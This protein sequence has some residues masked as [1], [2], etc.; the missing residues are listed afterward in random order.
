MPNAD[1]PGNLSR[2]T[3]AK[4]NKPKPRSSGSDALNNQLQA[5]LGGSSAL[6]PPTVISPGAGYQVPFLTAPTIGAVT[7]G[8]VNAKAATVK[9]PPKVKAP[10]YVAPKTPK[11]PTY[12]PGDP[13]KRAT[14]AAALEYDPQIQAVRDQIVGSESRAKAS[15]S[16]VAKLY[17]A[18]GNSFTGDIN[19]LKA[20]GEAA[21]ATNTQQYDQAGAAIDKNY[22]PNEIVA[23][24]KSLGIEEAVPSATK[25][26]VA[27]AAFNKSL[28]D[29]SKANNSALLSAIS[30]SGVNAATNAKAAAGFT[31]ADRQ[32]ELTRQL[33][34][35][36]TQASSQIGT[37]KG[38]KGRAA[39]E[40][41]AQFTQ[42]DFANRMSL[43]EA[44]FNQT[45]TVAQLRQAYQQ[46]GFTADQANAAAQA[47]TDQFN[48]N[49]LN[50][51]SQF[52]ANNAN[53]VNQFNAGNLNQARQFNASA[54]DQ[55]NRFNAGNLLSSQQDQAGRNFQA[56][57]FNAQQQNSYNNAKAGEQND[58]LRL[59]LQLQAQ[60]S[61]SAAT[62]KSKLTPLERFSY[63]IE[64]TNPGKG[65][66]AVSFILG[67]LRRDN[68]L[69]TGIVTS[70]PK[71]NEKTRPLTAAEFANKIID[72]GGSEATGVDVPTLNALALQF[73]KDY[74]GN[75]RS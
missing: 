32:Q 57:Q 53:N 25:G 15:K 2:T 23:Q 5:L 6:T 21:Q 69:K 7:V 47:N 36:V 45:L 51:V 48:A 13:T 43:Q 29:T 52:N 63:D 33:S 8:A 28:N 37:L 26:D 61:K 18:L 49:N 50:Q 19:S 27:D 30:Q 41:A 11:L 22:D 68:E 16:E 73:W 31:G 9:A 56:S 64:A 70:G 65:S 74:S 72:L 34:D 71:G 55:T 59:A 35:Y 66:G 67:A 39:A 75:T 44:G 40:L 14:N 46:L 38:A 20:Q 12:N 24:L 58:R 10:K 3:G 4:L 60:S 1:G 54:A 42:Q 62:D 17:D